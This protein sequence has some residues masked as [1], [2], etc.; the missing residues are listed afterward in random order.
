MKTTNIIKAIALIF[1]LQ[2]CT[3]QPIE[4]PWYQLL[5]KDN[6]ELYENN[7]NNINRIQNLR[8]IALTAY[9][10]ITNKKAHLDKVLS[11]IKTELTEIEEWMLTQEQEAL[12]AIKEKY[13]IS[14]EIW[15]K[16]LADLHRMKTIFTKNLQQSHP[17]AIHDPNIPADIHKMLITLLEQNGINPQSINLKMLT[18]Q[19]INKNPNLLACAIDH[20]YVLNEISGD[21]IIL[22]D[23]LPSDIKIFPLMSDTKSISDTMAIC[24]HEIQHIIQHH[25]LT[26]SLLQ[27]YLTHYY[28]IDI[29]E[30]K[31]TPEYI[32]FAQ[33]HEAQAEILSATKNYKIAACLKKMRQKE[34]Y[35]DRLYEDHFFHLAYINS[36]WKMH[37]WLEYFQQ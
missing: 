34:Y 33:V 1:T 8:C 26:E 12:L 7:C 16:Y 22:Y 9:H 2:I 25:S 4:L 23:Y 28:N 31:Q 11:S 20:Y 5:C 32:A 6:G 10:R 30:F 13:Q 15:Q 21:N 19:E 24:A 14:N 27:Q 17:D 18:Q 37:G 3:V 29:A 35:P 36:L